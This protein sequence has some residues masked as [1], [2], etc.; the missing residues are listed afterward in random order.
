MKTF[1]DT[2]AMFDYDFRKYMMENKINSH[3][4]E[5]YDDIIYVTCGNPMLSKEGRELN[6]LLGLHRLNNI[7]C[8]KYNSI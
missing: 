1:K 6:R 2:K 7:F 8:N 4:P 5:N 3:D